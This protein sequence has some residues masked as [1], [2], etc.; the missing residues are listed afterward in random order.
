M[1]GGARG[2]TL[3]ATFGAVRYEFLMQARRWAVWIAMPLFVAWGLFAFDTFVS[4][5]GDPVLRAAGWAASGSLVAQS[6]A[7]VAFGIL[8][9]DR[10]ARD[11]RIK[12]EELLET[13]PA[14]SGARMLGKY[15]GS[16]TATL[17]PLIA[18]YVAGSVYVAGDTG[19][20]M[21]ALLGLLCFA[22]VNLPGL[23][24]VAAFSVS[25][26]AVLW[27]PLYQ[28]LFV[29]YWFWGNLLSPDSALPTI[30]G[31]ILTPVGSYPASG[32]F[33]LEGTNAGDATVREGVASIALLL[34][35]SGLTLA[36]ANKYLRRRRDRR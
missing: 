21:A 26:P 36:C 19:E 32:F 16:V 18:A 8:V 23:L 10:L 1:N 14:R 25:C 31:T 13:L 30:S 5:A 12:V 33:G 17:I 2:G 15:L 28:V 24:F 4:L 29:A 6:F 7:P 34:I 9:S 11:R 27:V 3:A 20:P 35:L 22:T